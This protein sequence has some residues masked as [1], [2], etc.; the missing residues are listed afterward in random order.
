MPSNPTTEALN[1]ADKAKW[2]KFV[3]YVAANKMTGSPLL[4]QR[5]KQ[6]GMKLLQSFNFSN[7]S[8]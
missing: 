7:P 1:P 6:V 2:N 5:N 8:D 4:D 3:D